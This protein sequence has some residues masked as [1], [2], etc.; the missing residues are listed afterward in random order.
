MDCDYP[1]VVYFSAVR[2]L[3]R[4]AALKRFWNLRQKI[5]LLMESKHQNVAFLGDE[6]WLSDLALV[7]DIT[8]HLSELNLKLQG[9][10]QLVN[11]Q[12]IIFGLW[13]KKLN[14]FSFSWVEP[15]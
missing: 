3:C 7:T 15:F 4:A 11:K 13:R 14:C 9:K 2:L 10:S 12:L 1:D 8:Q 5:K 6:K